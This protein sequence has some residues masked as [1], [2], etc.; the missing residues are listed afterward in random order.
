MDNKKLKGE[1]ELDSFL[2]ECTKRGKTVSDLCLKEAYPGDS[3]TSYIMQLKADWVKD[4]ECFD[5]IAFFTE[6][7]FDVMS[8]GARQRIFSIQVLRKNDELH[9]DSGELVIHQETNSQ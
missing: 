5:A 7:M 4:D 6:V 1:L 8:L 3:S 9:C 2:S